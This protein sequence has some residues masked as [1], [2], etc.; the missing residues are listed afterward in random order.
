MGILVGEPFYRHKIKGIIHEGVLEF[1]RN[2]ELLIRNN[3]LK[4]WYLWRI[5][6]AKYLLW[7]N[8]ENKNYSSVVQEI[9]GKKSWTS[10]SRVPLG[11]GFVNSKEC[12]KKLTQ[13]PSRGKFIWSRKMGISTHFWGTLSAKKL[14]Q[15]KI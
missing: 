5:L 9:E 7:Y 3:F 6:G 14:A 11:I 15:G 13:A 10:T 4:W 8:D 1:L 12:S 2:I